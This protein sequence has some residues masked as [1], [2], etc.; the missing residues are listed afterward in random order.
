M[1][2]RTGEER[3]IDFKNTVTPP[4]ESGDRNDDEELCAAP[5]ES[6]GSPAGLTM[7][8]RRR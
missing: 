3:E 6:A 7:R 2:E 8:L 1:V 5:G 4:I